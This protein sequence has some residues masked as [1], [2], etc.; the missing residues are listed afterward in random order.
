MPN[1]TA[2]TNKASAKIL[3]DDLEQ[4]FETMKKIC[5]NLPEYDNKKIIKQKEGS[6]LEFEYDEEY[7]KQC[8]DN[9]ATKY[10]AIRDYLTIILD[11]Q[12]NADLKELFSIKG[13]FSAGKLLKL[14]KARVDILKETNDSYLLTS[15]LCGLTQSLDK[16]RDKGRGVV[17]AL[18]IECGGASGKETIRQQ[19][20]RHL[21]W[22]IKMKNIGLYATV[23][24]YKHSPMV[25]R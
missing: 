15:T 12:Q 14:V 22:A 16:D 25:G 23:D 21:T 5:E 1:G 10:K 2:E 8:C 3:Y 18:D 9:L 7:L 11:S 13:V 17:G 4:G 6:D 24:K 19:L 20:I